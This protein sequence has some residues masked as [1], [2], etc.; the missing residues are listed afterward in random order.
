[1]GEGRDAL[2]VFEGQSGNVHVFEDR[3]FLER[4]KPGCLNFY[5]PFPRESK[6]IP[7]A[8]ITA[9]QVCPPNIWG[10]AGFIQF[11][12]PGG[13]ASISGAAEAIVDEN[14]VS[15][16]VRKLTP[17]AQ[18][19]HD[20]V[21]E[22]K[23]AA[24]KV[25]DSFSVADE[26][27]KLKGL[28]DEGVL[29]SDEFESQKKKLLSKDTLDSKPTGDVGKPTVAAAT[30]SVKTKPGGLSVLSKGCLLLF[31]IPFVLTFLSILINPPKR[32][33]LNIKI[34]P[35]VDA[36]VEVD[37]PSSRTENGENV[38]FDLL[39]GSYKMKVKAE[40]YET[41]EGSFEIPRN[42]NL[43]VSLKPSP[44]RTASQGVAQS[45][46]AK[47]VS[48]PPKNEVDPVKLVSILSQP[49]TVEGMQCFLE[50][51]GEGWQESRTFGGWYAILRRSFG[52]NEVSCLLESDRASTVQ[53]ISLEAEFHQPGLYENEMLL[54]FGQSSVILMHP[55]EP[56]QGF[57]EALVNMTTWSNS[58]WELTRETYQNGGFELAL[59]KK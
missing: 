9:I 50:A 32:H 57:T 59:R 12:V 40:G 2:Y 3:V 43:A 21:F 28:F 41:Y 17:G 25:D 23:A 49:M 55:M 7:I 44:Q 16:A 10:S 39:E 13:K 1:M 58:Q 35:S 45:K 20:L 46:K 37:G 4:R 36:T 48:S 53:R 52:E 38:T 8:S 51:E 54:Q 34:S 47:A 30:P 14:C 5:S 18:K 33:W 22:L 19:V 42:K 31:A 11:T 15:F 24:A 6:S 26:I 27:K 56:P 29:T